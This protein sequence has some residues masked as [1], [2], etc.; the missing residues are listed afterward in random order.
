MAQAQNSDVSL[1]VGLGIPPYQYQEKVGFNIGLSSDIALTKNF[2][3]SGCAGYYRNNYSQEW[4]EYYSSGHT[5]DYYLMGGVFIGIPINNLSISFH[6]RAGILDE[7]DYVSQTY[8]TRTYNYTFQSNWFEIN[9]GF[10]VKYSISKHITVKATLDIYMQDFDKR[11][12]TGLW[13]GEIYSSFNPLI[14][15]GYKF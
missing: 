3:I 6:I 1:N 9:P 4:I 2:G 7:Y 13:D 14:G 12:I 15:I 11:H 5:Q 8:Y 10:T